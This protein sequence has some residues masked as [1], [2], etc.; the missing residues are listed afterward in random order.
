MISHLCYS[1]CSRSGDI[2]EPMLKPQW[3]VRTDAMA[4]AAAQAARD[5]ELNIIP[6]THQDTWYRW[7][8][9]NRD[10]CISRQLWWG[11]R[12]PA[13][14]FY[15]KGATPASSGDVTSWIAAHDDDEARKLAAEKLGCTIDDVVVAQ[16][17]NRHS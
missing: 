9:N 2:I 1:R 3:W 17:N 5:G 15:R 7:L 6:E 8:D 16:V 12:I 14:L 10:W 4:K 11:H 13:Y